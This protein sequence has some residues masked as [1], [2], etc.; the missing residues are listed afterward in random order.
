MGLNG[1]VSKPFWL[2]YRYTGDR[3]FLRDTA[4]PVLR[5]YA[6]FT[7]T[8]LGEEK[9]GRLHLM[10]T[11]SPEHWG[12]TERFE[13]NRDCTSPL[14]LTGYLLHAAASAA[15]TL[16][17]DLPKARDGGRRPNAWHCT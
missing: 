17:T 2:S 5:P 11:V 14:S 15:E 3:G 1:L 8:Y 13:R 4:Y 10:P 12:L 16:G 7:A 9:D 6:R